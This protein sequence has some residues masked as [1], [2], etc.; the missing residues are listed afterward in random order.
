MFLSLIKTACPNMHKVLRLIPSTIFRK[1]ILQRNKCPNPLGNSAPTGD[2]YND[3]VAATM[4]EKSWLTSKFL[5]WLFCL[6]VS[7]CTTCVRDA[8]RGQKKVLDA[9]EQTKL[10]AAM[11]G[12]RLEPKSPTRTEPS[13]LL[14]T[15][16]STQFYL[17]LFY[18][19]FASMSVCVPC[20]YLVLRK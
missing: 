3:Q 11:W 5:F 16:P 7:L 9:L 10:C 19:C 8:H 4:S 6:H 20:V 13:V 2:F 18:D 14:T 17:L 15:E 1:I 12:L